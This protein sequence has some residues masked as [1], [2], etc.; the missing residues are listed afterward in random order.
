MDAK[1]IVQAGAWP[2]YTEYYWDDTTLTEVTKT[3]TNNV[4]VTWKYQLNSIKT[5]ARVVGMSVEDD[6]AV[7][8]D[9]IEMPSVLGGA[10]VTEIGTGAFKEDMKLQ[11][12]TL[13]DSLKKI[14]DSAFNDCKSLQEIMIPDGVTYIGENAF[15]WCRDLEKVTLSKQL[16]SIENDCFI[17]CTGLSEIEI[18]VSVTAIH[19]TAFE[20]CI[21]LSTIYFEGSKE[22][23]DKVQKGE[24]WSNT[25]KL[26]DDSV[27]F[28]IKTVT[29]QVKN[30]KWSDGKTEDKTVTVE[31]Y[32]AK[33]NAS[34]VPALGNPNQGYQA[35]SWSEEL[36][37]T[38]PV[39]NLGK[40]YVYSFAELPKYEITVKAN[41]SMGNVYDGYEKTVSGFVSL[42]F[43]VNGKDYTVEGLT[44]SDPCLTEAGTVENKIDGTAVVKDADGNDVTAQFN[45]TTEDGTLV[46][47]KREVTVSVADKEVEYNGSEQQGETE[48][49]FTNL[50]SGHTA[51]ISYEPAMG[52]YVRMASYVGHF[53][54]DYF[55]VTDGDGNDV[56]DNY[57]VSGAT[58]GKLRI[59]D[60]SEKYVIKVVAKSS[61]GNVYDG[62]EKS[63][64]GFET[65]SFTVEG[66]AYTVSGLTTSDP[67]GT[68][69]C[70]LTN[71]ISGTAVVRDAQGRDVTKQFTVT[72]QDGTLEITKREVSVSVADKEVEYNGSEQQGETAYAFANVVSGQTATI[73]YVPAKGKLASA[74]GYDNGSFDKNSFKVVD[75]AGNDVTAN[76]DLTAMTAGKLT[77]K[78]R[79]EK[80]TIKV[81]ANSNTGNTYDGTEKS[82]SGFEKL[83]FQVEG[84]TYS[85]E[86]LSTSNPALTEAGT[87]ANE[88]T[89]TAVVKDSYGN[90]VT[91]QFTVSTED[92]TLEIAKRGVT[93]SVADKEVEYNGNEQQGETAYAFAN[94]VSG[95]T[96]TI[97][98][99]P[100]KGTL[101]N[102]TSYDNGSFDKSTF[103][104]TDGAGNDLTANY[105]L[106]T[107]TAGKLLVKDRTNKYEITVVA[108][109]NT[110]NVYDGTEK[111]ASGIQ[112]LTFNFDGNDYTVSGLTTSDPSSTNVCSLTNAVTGTAVVKDAN[113][114][115][116]TAQF[117][118]YTTDGVL[119]I[120]KREV[121]VS[122]ADKEAEY[123]GNEQQG[124]TAY[125]FTNVV[126]GQTAT[127]AYAPAKGKLAGTT[128]YDN[129]SFDKNSFK[130]VDGAG[131]DVTANY[132]LTAM[133]AGK[134]TIKDRTEKYVIT[135]KSNGNTGNIYDRT[136]KSAK[137]FERLTFQVEGKT[138]TV[139]GLTSSN[140]KSTGVCSL[141]NEISGNAVVKDA[142]GN[143]VTAQFTVRKEEG[144]LEIQPRAATVTVLSK[145]KEFGNQDPKFAVEV[146]GV[147]DGDALEITFVREIGEEPGTYKVSAKVTPNANYVITC[148]DGVLT[149]N[150]DYVEDLRQKL[151]NAIAAGGEQT[152]T[153]NEGTSLP[154][155]VMKLLQDHPQITLIFSYTYGGKDYKVT[156]PGKIARA[157]TS[158]PWYGPLYLYGAYGDGASLAGGDD[159]TLG[160]RI[161]RVVKGDCLSKI[162][163]KLGLKW[164]WLQK[165]NNL[166]NPNLIYPGQE[167]RY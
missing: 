65:L 107:M 153:W 81:V 74:T 113:G 94:V 118:V 67:S 63:V 108:N 161:Y 57:R 145:S 125:T 47:A 76:Y 52:T 17:F 32:D 64:S 164:V 115:D 42:S 143:D 144:K 92:G 73:T 134:L 152:V 105:D 60:R 28:K 106:T 159:S 26:T 36:D 155:D 136:E 147:L 79:S 6:N 27:L 86:G 39:P 58:S 166:R 110:G 121:S 69:V 46:I 41:S 100:A 72:T 83:M 44:T 15:G 122:V 2:A 162:A 132:D 104:V 93:V 7:Y 97:T 91:A 90:D 163:R 71:E 126:S 151:L 14:G 120:T 137:G 4:S 129:G 140:P 59:N 139:E 135:V 141:T 101:A 160:S 23:W 154:Y 158:I 68:N 156:I 56:T 12:M 31:G 50:V 124:E 54:V 10:K 146:T 127:I 131:N 34:S 11:Q 40:T 95:E 149:I 16:K 148:V 109:S 51:S 78:D 88:I 38:N 167:I 75:G 18:P 165:V 114:N 85:V 37:F 19:E 119:E 111:N 157:Y 123:N 13:P 55:K 1:D 8:S 61:T 98:Y 5:E 99:V 43:T 128:G 142:D 77:I 130:I 80:Y 112:S 21:D 33:L 150:K 117:T 22:D 96:A 49:V 48:Y 84:K 70:S 138:Y 30:G 116:V 87:V 24:G 29:F 62:T 20:G 9:F 66:N 82:V 25:T 3:P 35:G 45:V 102:K 133:T 53:S 103:K 89:G